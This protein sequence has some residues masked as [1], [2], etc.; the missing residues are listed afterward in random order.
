MNTFDPDT[1]DMATS[2]PAALHLRSGKLC[3]A[4]PLIIQPE[5]RDH[6]AAM[7]TTRSLQLALFGDGLAPDH[8]RGD[9]HGSK[10]HQSRRTPGASLESRISKSS[11][12]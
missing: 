12:A 9:A 6:I 4:R 10:P 7:V 8:A 3:R 2:M 11:G 1:S 5:A